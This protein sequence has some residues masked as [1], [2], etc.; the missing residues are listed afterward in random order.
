MDMVD[1]YLDEIERAIRAVDRVAVR[2]VVDAL[3]GCWRR[4]GTTY[5]IGNGGSAATASHMMNDLMKC[6]IVEGRPRVRAIALTDNVPAMTAF[7]N[8]I[9]YEEIF[10]EPLRAVLRPTDAVL[11]LSGSGNSPNVVRAIAFAKEAGA[12]TIGLCG[13]AGGKL[14]QLAD[15]A[16]TI[17]AD[18]IGQQEDG[19]LILNHTIA[20]ALRDRIAASA[21]PAAV[22]ARI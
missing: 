15:F 13:K 12:V 17:P 11:A 3:F 7:A 22:L 10:V 5:L 2:A 1:S 9:A 21:A 18:R 6:T 14:A 19:H 16:I 4:G 8:D 20:L